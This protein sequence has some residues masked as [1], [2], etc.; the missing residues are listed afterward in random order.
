MRLPLL[1]SGVGLCGGVHPLELLGRGWGAG[2]NDQFAALWGV[3][4]YPLRVRRECCGN[5]DL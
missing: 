4:R 3:A 5:T 2:G 1:Q